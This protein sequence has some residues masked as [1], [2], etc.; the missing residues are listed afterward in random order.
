MGFLDALHLGRNVV[1]EKL[2]AVKAAVEKHTDNRERQDLGLPFKATI[3]G[4]LMIN[5]IAMTRVSIFGSLLHAPSDSSMVIKAISRIR[6]ENW[7][8]NRTIYRYY[9][10]TGDQADEREIF[11]Q[12]LADS[13]SDGMFDVKEILY[14]DRFHRDF[15][16]DASQIAFYKGT[17][18]KGDRLGDSKYYFARNTLEGVL[19][20]DVMK[21]LGD[22]TE[23]VYDRS[24]SPGQNFVPPIVATEVRLDDPYGEKGQ[25]QELAFMSYN[26]VLV[27]GIPP[28]QLLIEFTVVQSHDGAREEGVYADF[29]IGMALNERE[30]TFA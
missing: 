22:K 12:V 4:V 3:G 7:P 28:E 20:S 25:R 17:T 21:Q 9:L 8:K 18:R 2:A 15:P 24:I 23:V 14:F 26:R 29:Y 11:V 16:Q 6:N 13:G 19:S 30:V 1:A 10:E 5:S 27:E